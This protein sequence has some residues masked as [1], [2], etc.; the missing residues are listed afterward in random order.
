MKQRA[1]IVPLADGNVL[2]LGVGSGLN[3]PF[4]DPSKV[5]HF[6]ALDPSEELLS[7]A[8][9]KM[10]GQKIPVDYVNGH[11]EQ[12]PLADHS[13]DTIVFTYTLCTIVDPS[14]AF[15]EMR[16]VLKPGGKLLFCE[17][18]K[19]PDLAVQRW[20]NRLNPIWKRFA[21]GCNLNRNI[22]QMLE[23]GGFSISQM[24]RMYIPGVK[25][26]SYNYWGAAKPL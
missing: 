15:A 5:A 18:G 17:H 4:Y 20:Q 23:E 19:A 14:S 1:K 13:V 11:A 10:N 22:P 26:F 25:F 12:I 24:E 3:F 8:K 6:I 2:E 16:K 7:M 9:G 21:G